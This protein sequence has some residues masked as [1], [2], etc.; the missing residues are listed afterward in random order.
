VFGICTP[1]STLS[2]FTKISNLYQSLKVS[3]FGALAT[4]EL[5]FSSNTLDTT[6]FMENRLFNSEESSQEYR[7]QR[8]QNP[9]FKPDFKSGNFFTRDDFVRR[10]ALL[11]T[12]SDM[13][14]GTRKPVWF[15]SDVY[16][17]A[18]NTLKGTYFN[19]F[20]SSNTSPKGDYRVGAT[21]L[22]NPYGFF[23]IFQLFN[24]S[25]VFDQNEN[26]GSISE[27]PFVNQR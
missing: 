21:F 3:V 15:L 8:H 4:D 18:L 20:T 19:F 27:H 25:K 10:P 12:I 23:N 26:L 22:Q 17:D 1:N 24:T 14:K 2:V 5:R 6:S 7:Y 11:T 13:T 9:I 16:L